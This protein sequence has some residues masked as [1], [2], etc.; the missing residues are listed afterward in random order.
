MA[1]NPMQ[2][3][4]GTK[5]LAEVFF[6][7]RIF[8]RPFFEGLVTTATNRSRFGSVTLELFRRG[9]DGRREISKGTCSVVRVGTLTRFVNRT[10]FGS[11]WVSNP[12]EMDT[13]WL[14]S[15]LLI[16]S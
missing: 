2:R 3:R 12:A 11:H 5:R 7:G 16:Y 9:E 1:G 13:K 15:N 14:N 10:S 6:A 8:A 4:G